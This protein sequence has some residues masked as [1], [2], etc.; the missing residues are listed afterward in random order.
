MFC[1]QCG[2]ELNDAWSRC[3]YCGAEIEKRT[4][5]NNVNDAINGMSEAK[6]PEGESSGRRYYKLQGS[7]RTG[8]F[9]FE[10]IPTDIQVDSE[11]IRVVTHRNKNIENQFKKDQI[12][13]VTLPLSQVWVISDAIRLVLFAILLPFSCGLSIFAVI[14][15]ISMATTRHIKIKLK[16]GQA[17]KIP[18]CQKADASDFL[19]ELNYPDDEIRKNNAKKVSEKQW[20]TREWI[21]TMILIFVAVFTLYLGL[22]LYSHGNHT[23]SRE[24]NNEAPAQE[25]QKED[26]SDTDLEALMGQPEENLKESEVNF[27]KS[28]TGYE[29][30]GGDISVEC[31]EGKINA[32]SIKGNGEKLPGYHG[33]KIGMSTDEADGLL[34]STYAEY[35]RIEEK[36]EYINAAAGIDVVLTSDGGNVTEITAAMLTEDELAEY[37]TKQEE[38][39]KNSEEEAETKKKKAEE[40][41]KKAEEEKKKARDE[42]IF[43]DSD[44]KYLTEDEILKVNVNTLRIARNE[45]FARHGYIFNSAD[46]QKHFESTSWYKGTVKADKFNSDKEFNDFEKK[47]VAL[48]KKIEDKINGVTTAKSFT[49]ITGEYQCG[50]DMDAGIISVYDIR[51]GFVYMDIGTHEYP[52]LLENVK[53][54]I[55]DDHT[56][57]YRGMTFIWTDV[58]SLYVLDVPDAFSDVIFE[59]ADY[60]IAEYYHVS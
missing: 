4:A 45:I 14:L 33:I 55:I 12:E 6:R 35:A 32:V 25:E 29:L 22:N 44:K 15:A 50:S 8:R 19:K 17:V 16:N 10:Y 23:E 24:A 7:R 42:Y 56:V 21:K 5:E 1:I 36:T 51:D 46:L 40:E 49:G 37:R 34:K 54:E 18:I 59:G 26:L 3:P 60:L 13:S 48:I 39:K 9:S 27:D 47:N 11:N 2:K 57:T 31:T 30:L 43:P 28:E 52:Y 53:G 38:S 58:A 20:A 41:K